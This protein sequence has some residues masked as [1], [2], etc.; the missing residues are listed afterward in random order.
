[1]FTLLVVP[2]VYLLLARNH[3]PKMVEHA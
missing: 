3:V 1:V 2:T